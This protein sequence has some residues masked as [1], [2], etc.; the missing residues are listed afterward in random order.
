[1]RP[2]NNIWRTVQCRQAV[3]PAIAIQLADKTQV[4]SAAVSKTHLQMQ[5]VFMHAKE[6]HQNVSEFDLNRGFRGVFNERFTSRGRF[7][8]HEILTLDWLQSVGRAY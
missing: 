6:S 1:M 7:R 8:S 4:S 5:T 3:D 2:N